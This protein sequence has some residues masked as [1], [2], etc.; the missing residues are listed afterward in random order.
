MANT[1]DAD[2]DEGGA[3]PPA[4]PGGGGATATAPGA[5][6]GP[7]PGGGPMLAALTRSQ[8]GQQSS[9]PGPGQQADSLTKI[10][11]AIQ[12]IQQALPGLQPG[13]PPHKD[14]LKAV[15]AL[16]KH[17]IQGSPGAGVQKTMFSDML[18]GTVRNALLQRLAQQGQGR[19]GQQAPTPA[20][21]L[22]GA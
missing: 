3:G 19:P 9:A 11:A 2:L 18:Q 14:A 4:P 13:S 15:A 1:L 16:S 20:T 5:G 7:P 8:M 6:G 17:T 10:S 21:P 12:L 22:P